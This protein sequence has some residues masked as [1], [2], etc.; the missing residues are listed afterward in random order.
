MAS[1]TSQFQISFVN[2]FLIQPL[3][4]TS[5]HVVRHVFI[6]EELKMHDTGIMN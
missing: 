5:I 4:V 1:T 3:P 2:I 6:S